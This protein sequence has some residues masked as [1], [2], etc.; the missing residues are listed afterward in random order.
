MQ[1]NQT[2]AGYQLD[3]STT[4]FHSKQP[5][6]SHERGGVN[7]YIYFIFICILG[8][9]KPLDTQGKKLST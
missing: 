4:G 8:E 5:A 9:N 2:K 1:S 6:R 3:K 7:I